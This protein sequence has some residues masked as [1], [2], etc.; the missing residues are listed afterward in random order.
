MENIRIEIDRPKI[1]FVVDGATLVTFDY[2]ELEEEL[3]KA[4][5]KGDYDHLRLWMIDKGLPSDTL[6]SLVTEW[7]TAYMKVMSQREKKAEG[8]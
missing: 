4:F 3:E 7:T 1:D 2:Y 8:S 5:A 6:S